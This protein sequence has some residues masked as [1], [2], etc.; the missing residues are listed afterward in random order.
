MDNIQRKPTYLLIDTQVLPDV[1]VKVAAAK[2]MLAAKEV[3]NATE[4]AKAAGIS[5]S[6]L[7]KYK[8]YVFTRPDEDDGKALTFV[9]SLKDTPGVL[10]A[11]LSAFFQMGANVLSINQNIP[12]DSVALVSVTV[13]MTEELTREE[14]LVR[15]RG[16]DG[17][18]EATVL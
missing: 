12:V 11:L 3:K 15:L 13:R 9:V 14:L 10:Q 16:L 6:A 7:Y 17:V 18:V 2:R 4:A 5:R 8:D 1:F